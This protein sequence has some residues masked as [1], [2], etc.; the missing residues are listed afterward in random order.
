MRM[1]KDRVRALLIVLITLSSV[2]IFIIFS[3]D[4]LLNDSLC[5]DRGGTAADGTC[6]CISG[7]SGANCEVCEAPLF[8]PSCEHGVTSNLF[9]KVNAVP[10]A[11]LRVA[12]LDPIG[13]QN[14]F[15][16]KWKVMALAWSNMSDVSRVTIVTVPFV[17]AGAEEGMDDFNLILSPEPFVGMIRVLREMV[18]QHPRAKVVVWLW[19]TCVAEQLIMLASCVQQKLVD[20][21]ITP[22]LGTVRAL[23]ND[24]VV[25]H[26]PPPGPD[27]CYKRGLQSP[28]RRNNVTIFQEEVTDG[29]AS[30][31]AALETFGLSIV[32]T[33]MNKITPYSHLLELLSQ[34]VVVV[35]QSTFLSPYVV[36][37]LACGAIVLTM[38]P[39]HH[40]PMVRKWFPM[41]PV[42]QSPAD[43]N[44]LVGRLLADDD[45]IRTRTLFE[46]SR[47]FED[48]GQNRSKEGDGEYGMRSSILHVLN[49]YRTLVAREVS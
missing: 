12:I 25:L 15:A 27:N 18:Q 32:R 39:G 49:L 41:L 35:T 10:M 24:V 43:L 5:E 44:L 36:D 13:P 4:S 38:Q 31:V 14:Q 34:T 30:T 1:I 3:A 7:A 47:V 8:G 2:H 26:R 37:A 48:S 42:P 16:S 40:H 19:G 45:G 29:G 22:S 6:V 23:R 28:M 17:S 46:L 20:A 33:S 21:V 11:D 9:Q